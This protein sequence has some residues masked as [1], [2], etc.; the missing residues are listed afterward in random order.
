MYL[1]SRTWY[2]ALSV[3]LLSFILISCEKNYPPNITDTTFTRTPGNFTTSF[4]LTVEASDPNLDE[5]TY[6]W[7]ADQGTFDDPTRYE[8]TWT[9][10][11]SADDRQYNIKITVSD[12]KESVSETLT[13]GIAAPYYGKLSGFAYFAKCKVPVHEAI[14]YI[15]NRRD[16]SKIDGSY[17]MEGVL[18]GRQ[19][20]NAEKEGFNTSSTSVQIF[21]G[22]NEADIHLSSDQFTSTLS[23]QCVGNRSGEAK[24]YME[25]IILNPNESESELKSLS[26]GGGFYS[27]EDIPQGARKI[28]VKNEAGDIKLETQIFIGEEDQQFDVPIREPF[29]FTDPRDNKEYMAVKIKS[30]TWMSENLGYLPRVSPPWEQGG[31]WVYGYTGTDP[32]SARSIDNYHRYGCLYDWKTATTDHGNGRDICP[33]GWH[34]PTDSDWKSLELGLGM[35]PIEIDSVSWRST[36]AVGVKL[37]ADNG[38]DNEGNGNNSSSFNALPS[39]TRT[40]TGSFIGL[41]GF[42]YFWTADE[43]DGGNAWRRYLYYNR[44]GVGRFTD[45]KNS[46]LAVRCVKDN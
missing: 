12:G 11:E 5:L 19:T 9:G 2:A 46:G 20:L 25:V 35:N 21:E 3:L 15:A 37:K 33:P 30:Q 14:I 31:I 1:R 29:V 8:T 32:G 18:G 24:P 42:A 26:D 17:S 41:Y 6:L 27:I 23:G 39:G 45:L 43:F 16:T 10:P 22:I 34:V 40:T 38:W 7:E 44:E 4:I 28:I 36:S 13:I